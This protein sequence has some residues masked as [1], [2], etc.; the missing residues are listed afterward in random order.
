[1]DVFLLY[2]VFFGG[3]A[4]VF[5]I[6]DVVLGENILDRKWQD[7]RE[8]AVLWKENNLKR[9]VLCPFCVS[10]YKDI[11]DSRGKSL[12][13]SDGYIN[14]LPTFH[15]SIKKSNI[16][17]EYLWFES[18]FE[19]VDIDFECNEICRKYIEYFRSPD[20]NKWATDQGMSSSSR[21]NTEEFRL[22][23]EENDLNVN[24]YCFICYSLK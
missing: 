22:P 6:G 5:M 7:T 9:A 20:K 15:K 10:H 11:V 18:E 19:Q 3:C 16:K 17:E 14:Y 24:Y 13:Y 8:K 12:I 1:M 23:E 4:I 21:L 2:V